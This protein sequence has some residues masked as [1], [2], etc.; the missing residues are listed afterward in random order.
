MESTARPAEEDRLALPRESA[1]TPRWAWWILAVWLMAS[2]A[3]IGVLQRADVIAGAIC[4]TAGPYFK[5]NRL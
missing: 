4:T 1:A 5:G 2:M 3:G